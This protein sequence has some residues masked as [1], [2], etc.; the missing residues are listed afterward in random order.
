[1]SRASR[2]GACVA[3]T[4]ARR[5]GV[6]NATVSRFKDGRSFP[7]ESLDEFEAY[8]HTL[9]RPAPLGAT[10]DQLTA[11]FVEAVQRVVLEELKCEIARR[12]G[13]GRR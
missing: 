12:V 11:D 2:K 13:M 4:W 6:H 10:L 5:F 1:L 3:S 7:A 9:P 8:L